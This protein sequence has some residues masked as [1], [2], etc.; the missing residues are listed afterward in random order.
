MKRQPSECEKIIVIETVDKGLI[1]KIYNLN[2][3]IPEKTNKQTKLIKKWEKDIN[4]DFSKEDI[5]MT[6]KHMKR[7]L[8]S[9]IIREMQ[10]KTAMRHHL[11]PVG[12]A[13]IK[14]SANNKCS[15]GCGEKETCLHCLWE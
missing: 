12:M 2:N 4:R 9:L 11:T 15:R 3:S 5:Q 6:N 14:T 1:S 13:I 7:C 8:R 10:I